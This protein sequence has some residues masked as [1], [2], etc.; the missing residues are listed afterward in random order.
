MKRPSVSVIIPAFNYGA[1]IGSTLESVLSQEYEDW[2]CIVIDDGSTD[3]TAQIVKGYA[4]RDRR[5]LHI[6][7]NNQGIS[8]ARNK[9]LLLARG[10]YIQFLDA[11]DLIE[12]RKILKQIQYLERHPETDLVYGSARYFRSERPNKR[13]FGHGLS[14]TDEPWMPEISGA[15]KEIQAA[16]IKANIMVVHA[17]LVRR[18]LIDQVGAFDQK[19]SPVEDW[20]Y[21]LRCAIQGA[22]FQFLDEEGTLSLV[23]LHP[24][25]A[26]QDRSRMHLHEWMARRKWDKILHDRSIIESNREMFNSLTQHIAIEQVESGRLFSGIRFL[27]SA[28]RGCSTSKESLKWI[29][30]ALAAPFAPKG[31]F[32]EIAYLPIKESLKILFR[33]KG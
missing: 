22:A 19:L 5:I 10:E 32:D 2:E 11:D 20:D 12:S 27:L 30:A 31:R 1:F 6:W 15:G 24:K 4:A 17:P 16:L 18:R 7:Q 23:R 14:G 8:G 3:N 26:T 29:Y 21:W 13:L 28:A 33:V 9:G 25:S